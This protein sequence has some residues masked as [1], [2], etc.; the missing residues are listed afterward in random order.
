MSKFWKKGLQ[1]DCQQCGNCCTFE[2]G[3]VYGDESEFKKIAS[4][5]NL[6]LKE[7]Y[8]R[9]TF[10]DKG[11]ASLKSVAAGPCIFYDSGCSIYEV[12]PNQCRSYPFWPEILKSNYRWNQEA[13]SCKGIH[14]GKFWSSDEIKEQLDSQIL[15]IE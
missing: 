12:R 10:I 9:Y 7:F 8:D 2:G 14:S 1:F 13:K 15:V 3:A 5:L 6:S 4:H 11:Q